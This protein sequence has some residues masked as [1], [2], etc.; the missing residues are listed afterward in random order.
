M[1]N[2]RSHACLK[3]IGRIYSEFGFGE[4]TFTEDH[5]SYHVKNG[6]VRIMNRYK[7]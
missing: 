3:N 4:L 5:L 6:F 1:D 2:L 7:L